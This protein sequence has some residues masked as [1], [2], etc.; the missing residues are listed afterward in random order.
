MVDSC[1]SKELMQKWTDDVKAGFRKSNFAAL[2]IKDLAKDGEEVLVDTRTLMG[3]VRNLAIS[4][5]EATARNFA[6]ERKMI[7]MQ[8]S[9][10]QMRGEQRAGFAEQ[11]AGFANLAKTISNNTDRSEN[12]SPPK[13]QKSY[14]EPIKTTTMKDWENILPTLNSSNIMLRFL[15][16]WY[17]ED[18]E[19]VYGGLPKPIDQKT[20]TFFS[21]QLKIMKAL[22]SYAINK[23]FEFSTKPTN[24]QELLG[25][26]NTLRVISE[27][28]ARSAFDLFV[29]NNCFG[30]FAKIDDMSKSKFAKHHKLVNK[31]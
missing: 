17:N 28:C 2:P 15:Y 6:L 13:K 19:L 23:D 24:S 31:S 9:L 18:V 21:R 25:W 29:A 27:Q 4:H 22:K 3:V 30:E 8:Q 7:K 20:R 11:R 5:N 14:E 26:K 12:P 1:V 10:D 16:V